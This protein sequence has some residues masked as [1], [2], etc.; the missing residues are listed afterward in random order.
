MISSFHEVYNPS[1]LRLVLAGSSLRAYDHPLNGAL[2]IRN[3]HCGIERL[4][5]Y[6]A[7][8]GIDARKLIQ[9]LLKAREYINCCAHPSIVRPGVPH[10]KVL[11]CLRQKLKCV[12]GAVVDY[13][14]DLA[15]FTS[16]C[17][18]TKHVAGRPYKDAE[19]RFEFV[20]FRKPFRVKGWEEGPS[21]TL[22]NASGIAIRATVQTSCDWIPGH[23]CPVYPTV[24]LVIHKA[25]SVSGWPNPTLTTSIG[26][27]G[28]FVKSFV[29][30]EI[31]GF[32]AYYGL[33]AGGG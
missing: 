5:G 11:G 7:D 9:C 6:I 2:E 26:F 17:P 13:V 16:F 8:W 23:V 10:S 25:T 33:V 4:E 29:I 12:L 3:T 20:G 31:E 18:V 1:G 22:C 30:N 21:E 14:K 19:G 24:P 15:C 32:R 27:A 28:R